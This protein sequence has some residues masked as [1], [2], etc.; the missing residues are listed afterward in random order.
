MDGNVRNES[1]IRADTV[2]KM[3]NA[4]KFSCETFITILRLMFKNY[5]DSLFLTLQTNSKT[6]DSFLSTY[7]RL[8]DVWEKINAV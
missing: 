1:G 7:Q 2:M 8:A 6:F 4:A 5:C 3:N